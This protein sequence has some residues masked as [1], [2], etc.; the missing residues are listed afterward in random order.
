MDVVPP[1]TLTFYDRKEYT[2]TEA[3]DVL[4]GYLIPKGYILL[5]RDRFLVVVDTS[6]GVAP[7]LIPQVSSEELDSRGWNE[8]LT[9]LL[10]VPNLDATTAANEVKAVLS[11]L[12]KAVALP[13]SNRLA[14]SDTGGNLRRVRELLAQGVSAAGRPSVVIPLKNIQATEVAK[15][16]NDLLA[17]RGKAAPT[18]SAPARSDAAE[19]EGVVVAEAATNSILIAAPPAQAEEIRHIIA[20][21]D[22]VPSQV[23]IQALLVEVELGDTNERGVELGF[24]DSVLFDR[25]VIDNIVTITETVSN[26]ATGI[27]T[28]NQ[29]IISQTAEPGFNFNNKP[30]GN[31]TAIHPGRLGPQGLSN[32]GVGRV[33]GDLGFGGLV[34]SAGSNSVSILLR[35]LAAHFKVDVLSRPQI[36]TLDN[37]AAQ[38]QIGQQVP[39]VD[40]VSVTAV[41]S[42]N[43]VIRQDQA[44]IILKVTPRISPDGTVVIEV[45]AEKSQ[46][47]TAPGSGVPIF[48]DATN[49]NV[50]EAPV[51]DITSAKTSVSVLTGQ[52]IVLGG[53]ITKELATSERKV[54]F[55]GDIPILGLAFRYDSQQHRRKE[56]L[57]FLTP[58]IIRSSQDE[59]RFK[60]EE[61]DRTHFCEEDVNELHGPI[62]PAKPG[63][64]IKSIE[65]AD[66][67]AGT[68]AGL[69]AGG[70]VDRSVPTA[71]RL[72]PPGRETGSNPFAP[73]PIDAEVG[74]PERRWFWQSRPPTPSPAPYQPRVPTPTLPPYQ[75]PSGERE[76]GAIVPASREWPS[77]VQPTAARPPRRRWFSRN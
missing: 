22:E 49:G 24:Q 75:P 64:T 76:A 2:P 43:P 39:V 19:R 14:V 36:R 29:R 47:Q 17:S 33:N 25:S 70:A 67:S 55:L 8:L 30:L 1:G 61:A 46:F 11:P 32:F 50:I 72:P 51:K 44:G 41:G 77:P 27:A 21:L 53:M 73:S 65:S 59:E 42:A 40:G 52:T 45:T 66:G 68:S 6:K 48:T 35:A 56:L 4:N 71:R 60:S 34:L 5:R 15:A 31:N 12:G 74:A 10:P 16:I 7:N 58:H 3:L 37:H 28:T 57:I 23:L 38:I 54:P 26:P 13:A 62:R 9:V 18:G 69:P 63:V 20:K